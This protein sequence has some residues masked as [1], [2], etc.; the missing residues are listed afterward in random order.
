MILF[1]I[2]NVISRSDVLAQ[3]IYE[4]YTKWKLDDQAVTTISLVGDMS[5]L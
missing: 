2:N 1:Y 4:A 5:R 3:C